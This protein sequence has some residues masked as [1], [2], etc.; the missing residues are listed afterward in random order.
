MKPAILGLA[1]L[2]LLPVLRAQSNRGIHI[3]DVVMDKFNLLYPDANDVEWIAQ[4]GKY[5]AQFKNYKMRTAAMIREDGEILQTETEIKLIAL[6]LA[7]TA[8]LIE[9]VNARK[10]ESA[11][12]LEN[13][14]GLITFKAMADKEEYWFDGSGHIFNHG[15]AGNV[16][17]HA[18][19]GN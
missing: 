11:A 6:P 18:G 13:E 9:K 2:L 12:I 10:I 7:A 16:G 14:T 1:F 3:P 8:Y 15:V 5:L 19:G 4:N 17:L